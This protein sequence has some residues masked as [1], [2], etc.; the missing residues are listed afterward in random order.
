MESPLI[1]LLF[2]TIEVGHIR[3]LL[4]VSSDDG[5]S[6]IAIRGGSN[7]I[8]LPSGFNDRGLFSGRNNRSLL[9]F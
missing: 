5:G 1:P 8:S 2:F 4:V 3:V 6:S 9:L 7:D